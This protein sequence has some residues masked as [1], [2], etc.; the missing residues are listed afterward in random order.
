MMDMDKTVAIGNDSLDAKHENK[1]Q[2][3]SQALDKCPLCDR[4]FKET[5]NPDGSY[6]CSG[7]G[8]L[9]DPNTEIK[10]G[11]E[12][13]GKYRLLKPLSA[14][15]C[16]DI[17][18]CHPLGDLKTRYVLKILRD[19]TTP[20]SQKRFEREAKLLKM[21]TFPVIVQFI[22]YWVAFSGSY[23]IMEYVE[24]DTLKEIVTKYVID[25]ETTLI[26]ALKVAKAL[27][28]AWDL[29]KI[30]HRDIKPSNIMISTNQEVRLLDFGMAKQTEN[31]TTA[32]TANNTGLGTPKYMSPEQY[33]N[34]RNV[35]F[36]SDI[37]SLGVTM[38]F[39][40][41]KKNPFSGNTFFEIYKNTVKNSPPPKSD[42]LEVCSNE[43]ASLIQ[44]MMERE[45]DKR[46]ASYDEL[47]NSIQSILNK[48][49]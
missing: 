44:S 16:G 45:P 23:I 34:A 19:L 17:Y 38:Y 22:D 7:C 20:G 8:Y 49:A 12:L 36:R 10:P 6:Q 27:K 11:A 26:I 21:L 1:P 31:D 28:F 35:D 41:K 3:A 39:L 32:I 33:K 14:G 13:R 30:V 40:L 5:P 43:C 2:T 25:E 48:L 24:G 15:G 9:Y 18:L 46:P 47:I 29:A 37:Y 4:S 42:F